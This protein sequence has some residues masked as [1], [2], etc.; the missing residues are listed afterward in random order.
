MRRNHGGRFGRIAAAIAVWAV[1][2]GTTMAAEPN[3]AAMSA[4]YVVVAQ[5]LRDVLAEISNHLGLSSFISEEIKGKVSQNIRGPS[6]K[7]M[8]ESL[9][10]R[11]GIVWYYDGGKIYYSLLKEN[12][13]Q[14]MPLGLAQFPS[15]KRQLSDLG[16]LDSRFEFRY[17]ESG[18]SIFVSGPP[19]YIELIRQGIEAANAQIGVRQ[20]ARAVSVIYGRSAGH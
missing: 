20:Q 10:N 11:Y 3:W 9:A 4:D 2:A 13:S 19:R 1:S 16:L 15:L 5:D 7:E 12:M 8:L 17:S 14:I 18:R 6:A